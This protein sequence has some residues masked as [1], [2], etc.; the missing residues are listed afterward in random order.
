MMKVRLQTWAFRSL[1]KDSASLLTTSITQLCN[2]SDSS[3]RFHDAWK[4]AKLK[5]LS[6]LMIDVKIN[7]Y[8]KV[9]YLGYEL[10]KSLLGDAMALIVI[11]RLIACL[12]S[13]TGKIDI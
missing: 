7:H 4:I 5:R 6:T 1:S 12:N 3:S 2:L 8:S 9:T 11:K 10:E 13:F